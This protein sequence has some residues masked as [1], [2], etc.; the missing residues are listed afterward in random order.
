MFLGSV[1]SRRE[2]WIPY[3]RTRMPA[4]LLR[5][6]E[7]EDIV[8]E[9]VLKALARQDTFN[10][11]SSAQLAAWFQAI[12][13]NTIRKL[14]RDQ[15]SRAPL[16]LE[17]GTAARLADPSPCPPSQAE[18]LETIETVAAAIRSLP[19]K[20]AI[21]FIEVHVQG[22]KLADAAR[23]LDL[24]PF[25]ASSALYRAKT[26]LRSLLETASVDS[27]F[28]PSQGSTALWRSRKT[29]HRCSRK[30]CRRS[31]AG[32]AGQHQPGGGRP[33]RS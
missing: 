26:K 24:T 5:I 16:F 32:P 30:P 11:S 19:P 20:Q 6:L 7:P 1:V 12:I 13:R 33:L 14:V 23:S 31:A 25:S 8:S 4:S 28:S 22:V 29:S 10:G 15:L 21:L 17:E 3:V 2:R 27:C 9:A 18:A